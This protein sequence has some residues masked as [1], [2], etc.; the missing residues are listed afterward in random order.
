M[1][2]RPGK[3]RMKRQ[4]LQL[5]LLVLLPF[6][7]AGLTAAGER[8][9]VIA[10]TE[11]RAQPGAATAS[12][13]WVEQGDRGEHLGRSGGWVRVQMEQGRQGWLRVWQIRTATAD[14]G[15]ALFQGL[16]RFSRGI[17][18]LFGA[19]DG[20]DVPQ[21]QVTATIGVRGLDA[22][23]FVEA[24]PDPAALRQA[25]GMRATGA[26]ATA[27]AQAAGLQRRRISTPESQP[28]Q[29]WEEW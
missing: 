6:L 13:G 28:D 5:L 24:A 22:G 2:S 17:A 12:R 1:P 26:E 11:L 18:G 7:P 3:V 20:D 21:T 14:E 9:E 25:R 19:S 16:K 15:N 29:N 4:P 27:F 10:A 8:V 23:E